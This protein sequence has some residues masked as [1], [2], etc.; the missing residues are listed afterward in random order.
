MAENA[1][2]ECWNCEGRGRDDAEDGTLI[3]CDVCD[4]TGFYE[5]AG[6]PCAAEGGCPNFRKA[7]DT[8]CPD[9]IAR[10]DEHA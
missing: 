2:V 10:R 4:G 1:V 8:L 7:G 5:E 6:V 3:V 9:H